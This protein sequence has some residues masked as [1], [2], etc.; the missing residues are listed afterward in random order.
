[1]YIFYVRDSIADDYLGYLEVDK[2]KRDD[3]AL[4]LHNITS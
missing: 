2:Q 4:V 3:E 1:M